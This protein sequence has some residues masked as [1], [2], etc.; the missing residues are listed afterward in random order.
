MHSLKQ[1][2]IL[3]QKTLT[4]NKNNDSKGWLDVIVPVWHCL[5]VPG[6][7]GIVDQWWEHWHGYYKS[8]SWL[9]LVRC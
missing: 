9:A 5:T 3:T 7:A 1:N 4:L 8:G 6:Q 2:P